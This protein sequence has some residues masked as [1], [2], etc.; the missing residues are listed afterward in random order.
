[1]NN[2]VSV[3]PWHPAEPGVG[4]LV[5]HTRTDCVYVLV[6]SHS[7]LWDIFMLLKVVVPEELKLF[8]EKRFPAENVFDICFAHPSA[9]GTNEKTSVIFPCQEFITFADIYLPWTEMAAD[10]CDTLHRAY[11]NDW[12]LPER[13][14]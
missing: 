3:D 4:I 6:R 14:A 2:G 13:N 7:A 11:Q 10:T 1:M 9:L 8:L 12:C 5:S